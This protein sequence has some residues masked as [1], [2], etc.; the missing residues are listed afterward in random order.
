MQLIADGLRYLAP[1]VATMVSQLQQLILT[2]GQN[3]SLMMSG[4]TYK[5]VV[6]MPVMLREMLHLL[7]PCKIIVI[8]T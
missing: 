6:L 5:E 4:S 2:I 7:L 8:A 1:H 3:L